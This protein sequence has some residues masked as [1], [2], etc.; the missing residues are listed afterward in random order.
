MVSEAA[1]TEES[2]HDC[3]NHIV[4]ACWMCRCL[5]SGGETVYSGCLIHCITD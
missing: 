4:S 2:F 3:H 5:R 1:A